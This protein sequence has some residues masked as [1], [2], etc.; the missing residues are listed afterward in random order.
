MDARTTFLV[1]MGIVLVTVY[2]LEREM[3]KEQIFWL[4]AGLGI[5]FGLASVYTVSKDIPS[6]PYY[7]TFAVIFIL[8]SVFYYEYE[9]E[10]LPKKEKKVKIRPKAKAKSYKALLRSLEKS[11]RKGEISKEVYESQKA[12]YKK[13]L[14]KLR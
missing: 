5:A 13:K 4:Y 14:K 1:A 8:I 7:I 2:Y 6:Y 11:Y 12:E 10:K 9:P 3:K